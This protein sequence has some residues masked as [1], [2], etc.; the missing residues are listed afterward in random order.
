MPCS[1]QPEGLAQAFLIGEAFIGNDRLAHWSGRQI[2]YGHDLAGAA[3]Q[4]RCARTDG[5]DRVRLSRAR[6]RA[7]RRRR[8]RRAGQGS[9]H[10]G[11]A[12]QAE[13]Q[14]RGDRAVFLRPTMSSSLAKTSSPRP[15]G[16]L[17]ITDLNRLYLDERRTERRNH[18]PRLCLA[19][20]RH[21]RSLLEAGHFIATLENRQGL[22]VACPE[23]IAFRQGWIDAAHSKRLR[24]R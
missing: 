1:R 19:R 7:L 6:S 18:G 13:I 14:L 8:V 10:R 15:R 16:E 9:S 21:A 20:Y 17:E 11:K 3:R 22:K 5:R 12:G 2:F 4:R 23:E 24:N